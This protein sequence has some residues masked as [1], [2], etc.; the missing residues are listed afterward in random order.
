MREFVFSVGVVFFLTGSAKAAGE[1]VVTLKPLH[2]LVMSVMGK[3]G[4][5]TLLLSGEA[6]PHGFQ[7]KP[8][9][10]KALQEAT[11]IFYL[12]TRLETFLSQALKTL[13]P[14][15]SSVSLAQEADVLLL[16]SRQGSPWED[17]NKQGQHV[18]EHVSH[19]GRYD[20][21]LWLDPENAKRMVRLITEKLSGLYPE[22]RSLY[23]ENAGVFFEK[24]ERL[25]AT[26]HLLLAG[27]RI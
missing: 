5:A 1:V 7:F 8:S 26:L 3:T 6:S 9:Q 25:E 20:W 12:D 14:Q 18:H 13:P 11:L 21:H 23:E 27:V 4:E 19:Q 22:N 10:L 17:S 16:P 15:V 2:S 24:S